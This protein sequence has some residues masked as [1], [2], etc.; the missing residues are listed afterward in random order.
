[1]R[2]HKFVLLF[3]YCSLRTNMIS[4][5]SCLVSPRNGTRS[6]AWKRCQDRRLVC[7]T[8]QAISWRGG[9]SCL[10]CQTIPAIIRH[11]G[12][13]CLGRQTIQAISWQGGSTCPAARAAGAPP[14]GDGGGPSGPD[15]G[16]YLGHRDQHGGCWGGGHLLLQGY[17]QPA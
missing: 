12:S 1:M 7:Q 2:V 9:S 6:R 4:C 5:P 15:I 8:I 10:D 3:L 16:E 17:P 11:G 13:I 14:P